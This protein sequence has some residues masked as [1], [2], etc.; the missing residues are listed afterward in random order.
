MTTATAIA[1]KISV[2]NNKTKKVCEKANAVVFQ[3]TAFNGNGNTY[4]AVTASKNTKITT[5][6]EKTVHSYLKQ[7]QQTVSI[8]NPKKYAIWVDEL[9]TSATYKDIYVALPSGKEIYCCS[10]SSENKFQSWT[11]QIN[12][13]SDFVTVVRPIP[14]KVLELV[15][16]L[17]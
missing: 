1:T 11:I 8:I 2:K 7:Y 9:K 15:K 5:T 6:S 12:L 4:R 3:A 17:M 10:T 13:D 16:S 14:K